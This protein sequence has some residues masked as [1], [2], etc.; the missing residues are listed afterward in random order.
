MFMRKAQ[1]TEEES[2]LSKI[3]N[4]F[5]RFSQK[6]DYQNIKII[7]LALENISD[8]RKTSLASKNYFTWLSQEQTDI[9]V[10][11]RGGEQM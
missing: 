10:T 2:K 5:A 7:C 3:T 9:F 11:C 6:V 8:E 1:G 4:I